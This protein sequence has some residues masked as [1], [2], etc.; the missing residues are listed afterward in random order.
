LGLFGVGV[1]QEL[2][3]FSVFLIRYPHI[4]PVIIVPPR[5]GAGTHESDPYEQKH[6]QV[7]PVLGAEQGE[8]MCDG[9]A[10]LRRDRMSIRKTNHRHDL[11]P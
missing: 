2:L 6:R 10:E 5:Q 8:E 7:D 11:K 9:E 3:L 4:S 1:K